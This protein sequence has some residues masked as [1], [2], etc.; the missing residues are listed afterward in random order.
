MLKSLNLK[1]NVVDFESFGKLKVSPCLEW[2]ANLDAKGAKR[3]VKMW[4]TIFCKN[5]CKYSI[6]HELSAV[7]NSF[8]TYVWSKVD[9]CFCEGLYVVK[10]NSVQ[11]CDPYWNFSTLK[12]QLPNLRRW[13][14]L[15]YFYLQIWSQIIYVLNTMYKIVAIFYII[16]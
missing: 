6:V 7:K 11:F 10:L 5:F 8:S 12:C 3:S 4:G 14:M 1:E 9:S 16:S 15:D 2:M 13:N